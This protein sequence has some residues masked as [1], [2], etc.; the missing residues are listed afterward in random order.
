MTDSAEI[1]DTSGPSSREMSPGARWRLMPHG[2]HSVSE[3]GPACV[4]RGRGVAFRRMG[5][6]Q[7][8]VDGSH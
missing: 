4:G 2:M 5:Q 1:G 6:A 8:A 7:V 3:I